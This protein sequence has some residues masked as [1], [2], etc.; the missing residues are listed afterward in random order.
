FYLESLLNA[1]VVAKSVQ[2]LE[3]LTNLQ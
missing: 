2:S 3:K 1:K